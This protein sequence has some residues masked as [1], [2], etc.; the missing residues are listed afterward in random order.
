MTGAHNKMITGYQIIESFLEKK[1]G[2][3][4][5]IKRFGTCS[6]FFLVVSIS[7]GLLVMVLSADDQHLKWDGSRVSP[8]HRIPLKDELNQEIIPTESYPLPFSARHT[9]APCHVYDQVRQGLHFN[10]TDAGRPAGRPGEPWV[11]ADEKTGTMLPLSYRKWKGMWDPR[12]VGLTA[13]DFTVLFGRH[14]T[15]GGVAEPADKDITPESRWDVSGKLEI[16]CMG[17]HNASRL[18]DPS[19]WA[20]Q[21]MR[22]NFR[23]AA[24]AA[25]GLGEVGGMA[26]RL[27]AT[28]DLFDGPD[29]DDK[30]WAVVPSVRYDPALFDSKHKAFLDIAYKPEDSRCLACHS[31]APIG[32][33]KHEFDGDVHTASGLKCVSC[34]RNGIGHDMVRG[35]EG[36]SKDYDEPANEAFTCAGCHL[37]KEAAKGGKGFSGRLGAPFPKHNGF[38]KIHFERLSCTVC[39]SGPL[40]AKEPARVR[41]SRANRLGIFG[42]ARWATDMPAIVEPVYIRGADKKL[43]PHR[44]MWPSFWAE[45]KDGKFAPLTP[46]RIL[47]AAGDTLNAAESVARILIALF[48]IP[49]LGGTPVMVMAGRIYELNPDGVLDV[50]AY[51]DEAPADVLIWAVRKEG[52]VLPLLP[53][54]DPDAREPNPNAEAQVQRVLLALDVMPGAPGEPV[55]LIKKALYRITNGYLEKKENPAPSET[56]KLAWLIDGKAEP[57]FPDFARRAVLTL[58]GTDQTLTEEQVGMVLEALGKDHVYV[59]GGKVFYLDKKGKLEA[60]SDEAAAPVAWPLAHEVRPARMALGTNGCTDCHEAGSRFLFGRVKGYGPLRTSRVEV[61]S[62]HSFMGLGKPYHFFFG[63]SF[64]VRPLFKVVLVAASLVIGAMLLIA[65]LLALGRASG[66]IE[67]R[68]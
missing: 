36:E 37:G 49:D 7:V 50:S 56:S 38:P 57:L 55:L 18:Q 20:R 6:L 68:R 5:Q 48:N 4:C 30:E 41:T 12:D 22:Q 25:A 52:K 44:V 26:S 53:E 63:L 27:A 19:E 40:P 23:W 42:I 14:L 28:W 51:P 29:P 39:H 67:K 46:D 58:T 61:R 15:G 33:H 47:A 21:V 54:F 60:G 1:N 17:C 34:H 13:W 43:A 45:A 31:T 65:G 35:Y 8:V 59:S 10:A 2:D 24:A 16:N 62:V 32:A 11:W 64:A 66:L 3:T 9:C